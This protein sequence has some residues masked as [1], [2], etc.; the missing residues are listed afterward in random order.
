MNYYKI[1]TFFIRKLMKTN[2]KILQQ[3]QLRP[4]IIFK[5]KYI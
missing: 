5:L 4:F 1:H 2:I 3:H